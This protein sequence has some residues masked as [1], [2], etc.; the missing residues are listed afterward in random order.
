M[1]HDFN[2]VK[3]ENKDELM[4]LF[5]E[6][7][8]MKELKDYCNKYI[9]EGLQV[10]KKYVFYGIDE[11]Y[12]DIH[13]IITCNIQKGIK[14]LWEKYNI[15]NKTVNSIFKMAIWELG[16]FFNY[17]CISIWDNIGGYRFEKKTRKNASVNNASFVLEKL[18]YFVFYEKDIDDLTIRDYLIKKLKEKREKMIENYKDEILSWEKSIKDNENMIDNLNKINL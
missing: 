11:K 16:L 8:T 7:I 12:K 14:E 5:K 13:S 3:F 6:N 15:D 1:F 4:N 18:P 2:E 9:A 10:G 17:G